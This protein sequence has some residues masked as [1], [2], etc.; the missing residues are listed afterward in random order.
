M[1]WLLRTLHSKIIKWMGRLKAVKK[2]LKTI[3]TKIRRTKKTIMIK[4]MK[5]ISHL[6]NNN[7]CN[8][9]YNSNKCNNSSM[10]I[11]SMVKKIMARVRMMRINWMKSSSKCS[12]N[13]SCSNN[14]YKCNSSSNSSRCNRENLLSL[15][16]RRVL[17]QRV[18]VLRR[19]L[20]LI[21]QSTSSITTYSPKSRWCSKN[22]YSSNSNY[23]L[24]FNRRVLTLKT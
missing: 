16:Q 23:L 6:S 20:P 2:R 12:N 15:L 1:R 7:N 10:M 9:S 19:N 13:I 8:Y 5:R 21:H 22:S 14:S 17:G 24:C 11:K 4:S 18:Q 3:M